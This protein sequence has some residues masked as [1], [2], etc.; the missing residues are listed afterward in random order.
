MNPFVIES[1]ALVA[2]V[3]G[4]SAAGMAAIPRLPVNLKELRKSG[5]QG[6]DSLIVTEYLIAPGITFN[7]D[8]AFTTGW[9]LR[10]PDAT[11]K[12]EGGL[13]RMVGD[14]NAALSCTEEGWLYEFQ[15]VRLPSKLSAVVEPDVF[16]PSPTH[17]FSRRARHRNLRRRGPAA[18]HV[19]AAGRSV[20]HD[21]ELADQRHPAGQGARRDRRRARGARGR[22]PADRDDV[23]DLHAGRA[24][25]DGFRAA[26]R[27][28]RHLYR[29][30][31]GWS[32]VGG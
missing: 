17:M 1:S 26:R 3:V 4:L 31:N 32:Y 2:T 20:A 25:A 14:W 24:S 10:G 7:E 22:L 11:V 21:R 19:P 28:G 30:I 16:L 29:N 5:E 12:T 8:G 23:A 18:G 13:D 6:F 15:R 9:K 27:A